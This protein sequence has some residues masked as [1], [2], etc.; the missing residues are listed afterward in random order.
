[1][2]E[3]DA[4]LIVTAVAALTRQQNQNR[5]RERE[6]ER[7]QEGVHTNALRHNQEGNMME[8]GFVA[9]VASLLASVRG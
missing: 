1:M 5:V 8:C 6:Q 3:G 7:E 9:A 4:R 2:N